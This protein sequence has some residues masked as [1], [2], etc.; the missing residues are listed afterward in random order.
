MP[1]VKNMTRTLHDDRLDGTMGG[2]G[3][4]GRRVIDKIFGSPNTSHTRAKIRNFRIE[5]MSLESAAVILPALL[6]L[7]RL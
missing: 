7:D 5:G 1:L 6:P 3:E 2:K 4:A